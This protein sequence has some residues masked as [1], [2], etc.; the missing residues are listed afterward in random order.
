MIKYDDI[1]VKKVNNKEQ[2][3]KLEAKQKFGLYDYIISKSDKLYLIIGR[4]IYFPELKTGINILVAVGTKN[5]ISVT[6]KKLN[7]FRH[8]KDKS[9]T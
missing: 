8:F 1:Q 9:K 3:R 2:K 5:L 7:E 6:N 4:D